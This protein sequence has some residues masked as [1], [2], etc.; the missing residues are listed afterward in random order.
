MTPVDS[1]QSGGSMGSDFLRISSLPTM[2]FTS[3]VSYVLSLI[4]FFRAG[5]DITQALGLTGFYLLV[6]I[7]GIQL[8]RPEY[9]LYE[10][11]G[12]RIMEYTRPGYSWLVLLE[13]LVGCAVV[14]S[15]TYFVILNSIPE[16]PNLTAS[17]AYLAVGFD[18]FLVP[19]IPVLA[20]SPQIPFF[21]TSVRVHVPTANQVSEVAGIDISMLDLAWFSARKSEELHKAVL[22]AF[23]RMTQECGIPHSEVHPTS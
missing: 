2:V 20:G 16:H 3:L 18:F 8:C 23:G 12:Q 21:K 1:L 19:L 13:G 11:E 7:L 22:E 6:T 4:W 5:A 9:R 15:L 17:V 14:F 10:E